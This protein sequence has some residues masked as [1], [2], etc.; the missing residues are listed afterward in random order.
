MTNV[1][2]LTAY[3]IPFGHSHPDRVIANSGNSVS[4]AA[5]AL[6]KYS[7]LSATQL[8]WE[9]SNLMTITNPIPIPIPKQ[10]QTGNVDYA[11]ELPK[12]RTI[13]KISISVIECVKKQLYRATVET[14]Q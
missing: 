8:A 6:L 1:F 3:N 2:D 11:S 12:K 14:Q 9:Y 4:K 10:S 7:I 5:H 13:E